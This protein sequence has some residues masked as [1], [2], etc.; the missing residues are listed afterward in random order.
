MRDC[1]FNFILS[2]AGLY[3]P[4]CSSTLAKLEKE[5]SRSRVYK[6]KKVQKRSLLIG[7]TFSD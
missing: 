4:T 2:T 1:E 5:I 3:F 7:C 6:R